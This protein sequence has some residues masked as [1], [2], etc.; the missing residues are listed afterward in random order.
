MPQLS[1]RDIYVLQHLKSCGFSGQ[2]FCNLVVGMPFVPADLLVSLQTLNEQG[3]IKFSGPYGLKNFADAVAKAG[4]I[5]APV[6]DA[7]GRSWTTHN[8][9]VL[10]SSSE[11]DQSGAFKT[12]VALTLRARWVL[13]M[14][15]DKTPTSLEVAAPKNGQKPDAPKL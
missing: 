2:P 1:D 8:D 15:V 3:L 11:S 4:V 12:D 10:R 14:S 5:E 13:M 7:R 6:L 9:Q